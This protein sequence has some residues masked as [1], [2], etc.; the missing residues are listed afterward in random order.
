[1]I[2]ILTK[3][4]VAGAWLLVLAAALTFLLP[5]VGA[6]RYDGA[7][8]THIRD[9]VVLLTAASA[10]N[11]A[12]APFALWL[13]LNR[14]ERLSAGWL[15]ACALLGFGLQGIVTYLSLAMLGAA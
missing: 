4:G 5:L 9:L 10:I 11:L 13:R 12:A 2:A 1:M 3:S 6:E 8:E 7:Y 15:A 14:P